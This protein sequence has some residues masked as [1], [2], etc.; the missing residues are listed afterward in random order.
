M[1]SHFR[2]LDSFFKDPYLIVDLF[3]HVEFLCFIRNRANV[4]TDD[5]PLGVGEV[6]DVAQAP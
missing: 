2:T 1:L 5:D 6:P 4:K 3:L